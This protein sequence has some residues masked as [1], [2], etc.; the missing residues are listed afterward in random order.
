VDIIALFTSITRTPGFNAF[1]E[2]LVETGF[3]PAALI[4]PW[5]G[6]GLYVFHNCWR[7]RGKAGYTR[8]VRP[9]AS[10]EKGTV[11]EPLAA[12][13]ATAAEEGL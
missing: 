4:V 6:Q 11:F 1:L 8:I 9:A 13:C 2:L 5:K 7:T 3:R 10:V 12:F